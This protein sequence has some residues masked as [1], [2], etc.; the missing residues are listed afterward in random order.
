M[1]ALIRRRGRFG[2]T[3]VRRYDL[4]TTDADLAGSRPSSS[5]WMWRTA[6]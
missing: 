4:V 1:A 6:P 3:D 2:I 5:P